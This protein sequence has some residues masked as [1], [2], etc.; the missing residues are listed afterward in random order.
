MDLELR[1][2]PAELRPQLKQRLDKY[3]GELKRLR[4]EFVSNIHVIVNAL[5]RIP[6]FIRLFTDNIEKLGVPCLF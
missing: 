5:H 6:A 3:R 1:D 4:K 2:V